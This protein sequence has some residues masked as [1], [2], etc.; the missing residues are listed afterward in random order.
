MREQRRQHYTRTS[1]LYVEVLNAHRDCADALRKGREEL[2]SER[3]A[4]AARAVTDLQIAVFDLRLWGPREIVSV[5]KGLRGAASRALDALIQWHDAMLL[6]RE[7]QLLQHDYDEAMNV[8]GDPY[9][10]YM[11][12]AADTLRNHSPVPR[13][14]E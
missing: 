9:T 2:A 10:D 12:T 4:A 13:L 11:R 6:G 1:H 5:A 8:L 7:C 14:V 3:L